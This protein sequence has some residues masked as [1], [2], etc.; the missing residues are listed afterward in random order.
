MF[1]E[2]QLL[3]LY[4]VWRWPFASAQDL[5]PMT[6]ATVNH[7]NTFLKRH[8][9][10]VGRVWV[11]RGKTPAFGYFFHPGGVEHME[12]VYGWRRGPQHS[13]S[14]LEVIFHQLDLARVCYR[15]FP[16]LPQSNLCGPLKAIGAPH[17]R[18]ERVQ[19]RI[20]GHTLELIDVVWC[21]DSRIDLIAVYQ[22]KEDPTLRVYL[23]VTY[24]GSY[25]RPSDVRSWQEELERVLVPGAFWGNGP[26]EEEWIYSHSVPGD[27]AAEPFVEPYLVSTR[28][29]LCYASL[30]VV[31]PN[32]VIGLKVLHEEVGKDGVDIA[33]IDLKC[34]VMKRL[35]DFCLYWEGAREQQH[36]RVSQTDFDA[37]LERTRTSHW[38]A[39]NGEFQWRIF[40][41]V[42]DCRGTGLEQ[43]QAHCGLSD[44]SGK[45]M[46]QELAEAGLI[47]EMEPVEGVD[48]PCQ[49]YPSDRGLVVYAQSEGAHPSRVRRRLGQ[50]TKK[51]SRFRM[52][53]AVHDY[54]VAVVIVYYEGQE[55]EAYSGVHTVWDLKQVKPQPGPDL[56]VVYP[57][58]D[59]ILVVLLFGEVERN[60]VYRKEIL[61]KLRTY[62]G[63][64]GPEVIWDTGIS[65]AVASFFITE[66]VRG[67]ENVVV[68]GG[69]LDVVATDWA[70]FTGRYPWHSWAIFEARVS[71]FEEPP[72][73][74]V[75]F[76][77]PV[78]YYVA[79]G[80]YPAWTFMLVPY[81]SADDPPK[82]ENQGEE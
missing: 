57:T 74:T 52:D 1:T 62:R 36:V 47:Q 23:P 63:V 44:R 40:K 49:Y 18:H 4:W 11:G 42:H 31:V 7:I 78:D 38:A 80:S 3:I 12:G 35:R 19:R 15:I 59:G 24:Y 77:R 10:L 14:R 16:G 46:V 37:V 54:K 75:S 61:N 81:T 43:I 45:R 21:R 72:D 73:P 67:A 29:D 6:G 48:A 22:A 66:T 51:D 27:E 71:E 34:R 2:V 30:L 53:R 56:M 5:R 13:A 50:Y 9:E 20:V 70:R 64:G 28:Q 79:K 69:D 32:P 41:F 60:A 8:P 82:A 68:V 65:L 58:G 76:V 33:V 25:Q 26:P 55:L 39:L 17:S